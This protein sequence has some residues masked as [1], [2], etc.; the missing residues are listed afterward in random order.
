MT[1]SVV[2]K[3]QSRVLRRYI[4]HCVLGKYAFFFANCKNNPFRA[5]FCAMINFK[6]SGTISTFWNSIFAHPCQR[7]S[8]ASNEL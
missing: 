7:T 1:D 8:L 6:L 2:K 4:Y 3:E 5:C